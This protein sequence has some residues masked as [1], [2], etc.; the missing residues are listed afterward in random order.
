MSGVLF[1]V[2]IPSRHTEEQIRLKYGESERAVAE[3]EK[4]DGDAAAADK[5]LLKDDTPLTT[6]EMQHRFGGL[7]VSCFIPVSILLQPLE[8]LPSS[9]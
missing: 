1:V 2:Y 6:P 8:P 4:G 3:S 5:P 9:V 7:K